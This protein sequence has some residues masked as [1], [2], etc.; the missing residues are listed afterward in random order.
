MG[1][2]IRDTVYLKVSPMK[3]FQRFFLPLVVQRFGVK[4]KL[5][6]RYVG[7]FTI[8]SQYMGL[9]FKMELA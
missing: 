8:L 4:G 1:T 6:S 2:K 9:A 3:R 5:S 7:P